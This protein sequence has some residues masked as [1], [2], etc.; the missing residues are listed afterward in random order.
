MSLSHATRW[1]I[2]ICALLGGNILAVGGLIIASGGHERQVIPSYYDKAVHY[3]DRIDQDAK[4]VTLGWR[5]AVHLDRDGVEVEVRDRGG[6][7]L[8]GAKVHVT[9]Y[10]RANAGELLD[11]D[12]APSGAGLYRVAR[13]ELHAGVYDLTV[14]VKKAG[15]TYA[16]HAALDSAAA[17]DPVTKVAGPVT[18][19]P[20][21]RPSPATAGAPSL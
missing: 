3:D 18:T 13:S 14:T 2:G 1:T 11:L 19:P 9:G 15:D 10:Q 12:L 21:L 20:G 16:S 7:P 5:T 4:N 6:A 8:T 17:T